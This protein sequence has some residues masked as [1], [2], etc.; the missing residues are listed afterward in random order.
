MA[1][2]LMLGACRQIEESDNPVSSTLTAVGATPPP[3]QKGSSARLDRIQFDDIPVMRGLRLSNLRNESFS[4]E[5]NGV[6]VGRF[7]YRGDVG[8]TRVRDHYVTTMPLE[9]YGW[10]QAPSR[11]DRPDSLFFTK[12]R[13]NC[14]VAVL[15]APR[16]ARKKELT[17]T[18]VVE[19]N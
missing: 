5:S 8:L 12:G 9:P 16:A 7:V 19:T 18:I 1:S 14:E 10:L 2:M 15:A 11:E 3:S 4:Y 17:V 13:E 6:R